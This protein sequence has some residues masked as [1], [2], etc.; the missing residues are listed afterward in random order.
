MENLHAQIIDYLLTQSWQ[1]GV[2]AVAIAA[3]SLAV[4]NKSAHVRYLLWLIVLAKCLV[5]PLYTITLAVLPQQQ[6]PE[7]VVNAAVEIP[8]VAVMVEAVP[9]EPVTLPSRTVL[10]PPVEPSI[11]ERLGEVTFRQWL[12]FVWI[13]GVGVF[14]LAAVIKALRVNQWLRRERR[15]LPAK[16]QSGIEKLFAELGVKTVP[17]VWLVKGIG[18]PF[19]WGLLRG[20]IY[21]PGNFVGV[22]GDESR[23]GILGHELSHILRF[24]AAVNLL[25]IIAQGIFWFHPF[26]WWANKKIRAEREKCCDEMAIARLGAKAK[27]YSS[28][29]VNT[30]IAEHEAAL[31]VPSLAI[32]GPVKN[33]EDRIKTIM[34]PGKRF[35]RR[36]TLLAA[37]TVLVLAL[38]A[39][40]TTLALT[41]R[42]EQRATKRTEVEVEK[43]TTEETVR[44][45]LYETYDI[46]TAGLSP[47]SG[48]LIVE[49]LL[50]IM[51][52]EPRGQKLFAI[53]VRGTDAQKEALLKSV[54]RMCNVYLN[55]LPEFQ[56]DPDVPWQAS[57]IH[58]PGVM[59]YPP[60]LLQ[61][62]D[63]P[64]QTL[65][66]V[67]RMY[68]RIQQARRE[69]FQA[70]GMHRDIG[71]CDEGTIMAYVC[72]VCM[73]RLASDQ[74]FKEQATAEQ[75]KA[76]EEYED[77][78]AKT[79]RWNPADE[80]MRIMKFAARVC[81]KQADLD[82]NWGES[83]G[84]LEFLAG[85][86]EFRGLRLD[87]PQRQLRLHIKRHSL[88]T[89]FHETD[90]ETSYHV[91]TG[92]GENVIVMF[93]ND[94]CTGIQRMR[95]D[96]Q[97][98][99]KLF[100]EKHSNEQKALSAYNEAC[101][102]LYEGGDRIEVAKHFR[103][104]AQLAPA[105][106]YGARAREL[107]V[108]LERMAKERRPAIDPPNA[109][110]D[111]SLNQHIED[112][113]FDLRD[114]AVQA[115]FVPGKCWVL[116]QMTI[117]PKSSQH[118]PAQRLRQLA[119]P[120]SGGDI[121]QRLVQLL[122]DRRPTRSWAGARNGGHVLR[123]C[124]VALEILADV[125]EAKLP[126]ETTTFDPRTGRDAYL[127]NAD[128]QSRT[129]IIGR[130]KAWLA[131]EQALNAEVS[132]QGFAKLPITWG[133]AVEGLQ[134]R[135]RPDGTKWQA[136]ETPTLKADIRNLGTYQLY[137]MQHQGLCE[138]WR[139]GRWYGWAGEIR[140][141]NSP[142]GPGREYNDIPIL[143]DEHWVS[144]SNGKPLRLRRRHIVRVAFITESE[145]G[146]VI[147]V[148][149]NPV[150][151]EILP[152]EVGSDSSIRGAEREAE[153]RRTR[154]MGHR[155]RISFIGLDLTDAPRTT[156]QAD[157]PDLFEER[158]V[159]SGSYALRDEVVAARH[160]EFWEEGVVYYVAEKK[161]FYIIEEPGHPGSGSKTF[162][163]PFEGKPWRRF[164][165][166][167]PRPVKKQYRF[168]IYLVV[169]PIDVGHPEDVTLEQLRLGSVPVLTEEDIVEYDWNEH[170]LK[171]TP[172]A[173]KRLPAVRS[174]W[175]LPF[176]VVADGHRC[177]LG[178]FWGVGSSYMPKVPFIGG[179]RPGWQENKIQISSPEPIAG[180]KDPRN[181]PQV[182]KVLEELGI[183]GEP[184]WGE[185]GVRAAP[186]PEGVQQQRDY[187]AARNV[188]QPIELWK[189]KKFGCGGNPRTMKKLQTDTKR[190]YPIVLTWP[191]IQNASKYVVQVKGVRGCRPTTSFESVTNSLRLEKPDIT[192]GR[193][194]WAVSVYDQHGKFMGDIEPIEP[195]EIFAIAD[196]E[197]VEA[198]GK[199]VMIDLNHS[200]GHMR[201]WG[202]YNH[203]QY[204]TRELLENAG[205]EVEVNERDLLTIERLK[206]FDLLIC[207]Y[208]WAGWP[209]F[210]PYLQSELPA[211]RQFVEK[212]GSLLVVGC[213]RKD[214]G[215][216]MCEA[217]NQLVKEFGLLFELGGIAEEHGRTEVG[218]D[219]NV[220]SFGKAIQVQLPVGVQGQNA[221]VLLN[222]EGVPIVRAKQIGNGKVIVAG[223]GM[224]FLD[225]YLGDFEHREPLHLIMFYDFIRYLTD[226]DWKK[227]CKQEFV[228]AILSRCGFQDK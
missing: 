5:P 195:V 186:E 188:P 193:Y 28:A 179:F 85:I 147:R 218:S 136:G 70:K 79:A 30:L 171:L 227:N 177:Y 222:F 2:L 26:V 145:Q 203:A 12:A 210:R 192:P 190:Q 201:G 66:I 170:F 158:P 185:E 168:A 206:S 140:A 119:E 115:Y 200:A 80:Q 223:A 182:R 52:K 204:M 207:H 131:G 123:Y 23:R 221:D 130:A 163:G 77:Y 73:S 150:E 24:D 34:R 91:Y 96:R 108:L 202:F 35:Y 205:F 59:A 154:A 129:E 191:L 97:T 99:L 178:A 151:I 31:P 159:G 67:T 74:R 143:L 175:G 127:G 149:S 169:N 33:I 172:E 36:P 21:L 197:P 113:I 144:K 174:V 78:R 133:V 134:C 135:L 161:Q 98:A 42:A 43:E 160:P 166:A 83:V 110:G 128:E 46:G 76:L 194:Q 61:L 107:A 10:A 90:D 157:L 112:L 57:V 47:L 146:E 219:Q 75:L 103:E 89:L 124:D 8:A 148:H 189:V 54:K 22:T 38:V 116:Q 6:T 53:A 93:R 25:Q 216:K 63:D 212:G 44:N 137:V 39:V 48:M 213:D 65:D 139:D 7:P 196:P 29:I 13:V 101:L 118:N 82:A 132:V 142:L 86:P 102:F 94:R 95:P 220:I 183:A 100:E 72:H 141:K 104:V 45:L 50:E 125:A 32:A 173:W 19:V 64:A 226:I 16:L 164:G 122:S 199:K 152:K 176:V 1:I 3:V 60:L 211:V 17:K 69:Y 156:N 87:M 14:V 224:S 62:E 117:A 187:E 126:N 121:V 27:D 209:G 155:R 105:T 181:D 58:S 20:S 55:E 165:M 84:G 208:Y 56:S 9:T 92:Q 214:D 167:E 11:A 49:R 114:V 111:V 18:Q 4:K 81:Q 153:A 40:P 184:A 71:S 120:A 15:A 37:M 41:R 106:E 68:L 138:L 215:G 198:N 51:Q 228:G 109:D 180:T 217:G 162:Y 225:C 88:A